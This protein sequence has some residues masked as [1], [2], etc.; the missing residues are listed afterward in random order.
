M[1]HQYERLEQA[2]W[3]WLISTFGERLIYTDRCQVGEG[4][5]G[6]RFGTCLDIQAGTLVREGEQSRKE[7]LQMQ[8]RR[9]LV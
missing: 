5:S 3:R 8:M 2:Q 7:S 6:V 1:S 4:R 9:D